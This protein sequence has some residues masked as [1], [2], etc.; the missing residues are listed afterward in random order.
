MKNILLDYILFK[1]NRK[2]NKQKSDIL[3]VLASVLHFTEEEKE[4][5]GIASSGVLYNKSGTIGKFVD[6]V[7][8]PLPQPVLNI[9]KIEGGN[10]REKWVNFLLAE[11]G[12]DDDGFFDRKK[13]TSTPPTTTAGEN[14]TKSKEELLQEKYK[15]ILSKSNKTSSSSSSLEQMNN[16]KG[17]NTTT[18]ASVL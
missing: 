5:V 3:Q 12:G 4:Q 7:V 13:S 11:S 8:A 16:R 10:V 14:P 17:K 2:S 1:T 15:R 6:A 9:D 18:T